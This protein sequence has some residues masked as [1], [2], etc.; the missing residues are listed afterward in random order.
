MNLIHSFINS[1]FHKI[2]INNLLSSI[3]PF[4]NIFMMDI[5]AMVKESHWIFN[6]KED[7][8]RKESPKRILGNMRSNSTSLEGWL[9]L[10][11]ISKMK[12]VMWLKGRQPITDWDIKGTKGANP[13]ALQSITF[14]YARLQITWENN[15]WNLSL[16]SCWIVTYIV[17]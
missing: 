2:F 17:S 5:E 13:M 9:D 15:I 14:P 4:E 12:K 11:G 6:D 7:P 3:I 1:S 16:K 10:A 8:G